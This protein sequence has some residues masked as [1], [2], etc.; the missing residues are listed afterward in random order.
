MDGEIMTSPKSATLDRAFTLI[1]LLVVIAIIAILAALL[2]PALSRA[3]AAAKRSACT[4][5]L[6]Q[7][8]MGIHLYATDNQDTLPS[9]VFTNGM[10]WSYQWRFF[11]E[12][13]KSYDGLTGP[14][15]S[16]DKLYAC[17]A[18]TF[19]YLNTGNTPLIHASMHD[20]PWADYCSYWFSRL[21][22]VADPATGGFYHGIA[23]LKISSIRNQVRTLMVVDQPAVFAY[24]WHK[25]QSITDPGPREINDAMDVGCFVDGHASYIKFYFDPQASQVFP[26]FYNPPASYEYQWGED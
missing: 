19:Y 18:D 8:G 2:L 9:I 17:P 15:S 10:P 24:S 11:K 4:S 6:R 25:P 14:S 1:E 3:K 20:D 12:L 7:I 5:N 26:C 21:N 16:Q 23:G 22:L 13:T